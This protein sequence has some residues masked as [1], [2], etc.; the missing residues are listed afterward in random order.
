MTLTESVAAFLIALAVEAGP[1]TVRGYRS[2][3]A[4]LVHA[5]GDIEVAA[6]ARSDVEAWLQSATAGK[7]PDTV[8]LTLIAWERWQAWA[9]AT[10]HLPVEILP[11]QRKPGGRQRDALPSKEQVKALFARLPEEAQPLFRALRLTGARPGELCAATI[12][13]WDRRAGKITL[14]Q[15]KTARKT[16]KPRVIAV[17]HK[18]LVEILTAAAG[19][20]PS[21]PLFLRASGRAWTTSAL[22]RYYR[23]AR[24]AA[25]LPENFVLYLTRHEH[26][27]DLYRSTKDLKSVAD[28]LGHSQLGTTMRYARAQLDVLQD[29]QSKFDEG[30]D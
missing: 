11:K 29:Q 1:S 25:G 3:L 8:R 4:R 28:A 13:D 18:A 14:Q 16:G 9:I 22:S 10:G 23:Q 5:R 7:A 27:T 24:E 2:R 17:G 15:H 6:L 21:G 20:R 19:D 12:A 30:L 26:A